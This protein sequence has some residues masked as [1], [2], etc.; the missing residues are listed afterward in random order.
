MAANLKWTLFLLVLFSLAACSTPE[1]DPPPDAPAESYTGTWVGEATDNI[2]GADATLALVQ[3]DDTLSGEVLLTFSVGLIKESAKGTVTGTVTDEGVE[4]R[5]EPND[6]DYCP[7]FA[8]ATRSGTAL[9][10]TYQGVGCRET[11]E[12]TLEL[13]KQ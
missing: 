7:Y 10:G 3:T 1:L 2:G 13:Q 8:K 5:L 4:M 6:P 9:E 12:G 11:I